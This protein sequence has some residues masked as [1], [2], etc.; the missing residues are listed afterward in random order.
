MKQSFLAGKNFDECSK[1]KDAHHL[2]VVN[3]TNLGDSADALDPVESL[4]H[5]VSVGAGHVNHTLGAASRKRDFVDGDGSACLF[6]NLL[7]GLTAL[8]DHCTDEFSGDADFL[9]ARYERLVVS[10]R[11]GNGLEHLAHDVDT[12]LA[13]LLE[14][15]CQHIIAEAVNFDI[16]LG[17][18]DTVFGT[19]HL[20]VHVAEVIL[21]AK[22]V[23]EDGIAVIG[24]FSVGNETHGNTCN[25]LLDLH[26][27]IH[28]GKAAATYGS[29]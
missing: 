2:S 29:H 11:L 1:I 7:D 28:E 6:L 8:S 24:V 14:C 4:L 15:L 18:G 27:C 26:T 10:A 22:D 23:G 25:G 12:S 20:E 3:F 13:C 21:V 19:G 17:C 16:H 9:D 5:G